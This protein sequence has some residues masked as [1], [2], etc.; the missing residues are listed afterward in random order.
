LIGRVTKTENNFSEYIDHYISEILPK[1][2]V[3]GFPL[4]DRTI[5]EQTR[6]L[7]NVS[8]EIGHHDIKTLSQRELA[9]YL[10]S[11]STEEVHNKY[12]SILT[13]VFKH[14]ISDGIVKDNIAEKILKKD[15]GQRKRARLTIEQYDLIFEHATPE[16]KN[17]MELSLNTIQR[18]EEIKSWR[19]DAEKDGY[20][21]IIQSKT[22]KHGKSAYIRIPVKM[23]VVHS[24]RGMKTIKDIISTCRDAA[25]CP[26]VIHKKPLKKRESKEKQHSMQL[27]G[28]EISDGFAEARDKAGIKS[29][30]PPTF[31]ELISLGEFLRKESG[32]PLEQIKVLRGHTSEKMTVK[33]LDGHDWNTVEFG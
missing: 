16:I 32:W 27:S 28:K 21:Y 8:K 10:N 1:R 11:L 23:P 19:F 29:A 33:Y 30:N 3:N 12:R 4:S 6:I 17:A 5:S 31:H 14:A 7:G 20:Y 25:L 2:K 22:R 15:I 18:R 26:F 13:T 9:K 24:A